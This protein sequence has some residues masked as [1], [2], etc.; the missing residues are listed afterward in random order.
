MKKR[1]SGMHVLTAKLPRDFPVIA[2]C[3]TSHS[4][5]IVPHVAP[6]LF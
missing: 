3:S 6:I 5:L 1:C 2:L 4:D